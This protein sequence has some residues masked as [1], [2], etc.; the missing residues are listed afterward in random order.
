MPERRDPAAVQVVATTGGPGVLVASGGPAALMHAAL[1]RALGGGV[2]AEDQRMVLTA[3][4]R[5]CGQAEQRR[6]ARLGFARE[7]PRQVPQATF[8]TP[9]VLAQRL[10]IS[11]Q[12]VRR[13]CRRGR[14]PGAELVGGRWRIPAEES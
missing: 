3:L 5:A 12:A 8:D 13:R 14:V 4:Q 7:T 10:G 6:A 9:E 2:L 1:G 11:V